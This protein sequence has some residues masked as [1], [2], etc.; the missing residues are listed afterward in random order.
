M[1]LVT[2]LSLFS[3]SNTEMPSISIRNFDKV[4]HFVFY[5]VATLLC[6]L[7]I[8]ERTEGNANFKKT[9]VLTVLAMIIYGIII[10][11][12][13]SEWTTTRDGNLYDALANTA[14][15]LV[16]IWIISYVFSG[17]KE[18]KWKY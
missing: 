7:Y 5:C 11:V 9:M 14:G 1:A 6:C 18:L 12:L 13:Q 2:F 15:A 8:R 16:G 17:K 4:V 3:I 10:E